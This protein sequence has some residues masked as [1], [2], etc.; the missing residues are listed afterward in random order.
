MI[1]SSIVPALMLIAC[2][3]PARADQVAKISPKDL[4]AA[5]ATLAAPSLPFALARCPKEVAELIKAGAIF[6]GGTRATSTYGVAYTL[7]ALTHGDAQP[8]LEI[9][10]TYRDAQGGLVNPPTVEC[11]FG[12]M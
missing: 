4:A 3:S 2:A 9:R 5:N 7:Y 1:R 10:F 6:D 11:G 8:F 12:Q